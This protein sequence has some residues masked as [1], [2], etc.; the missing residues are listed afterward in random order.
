MRSSWFIV[1]LILTC[2]LPSYPFGGSRGVC[3]PKGIH[4]HRTFVLKYYAQAA[5]QIRITTLLPE[6]CLEK[7]RDVAAVNPF[8][9][10]SVIEVTSSRCPAN[11]K[12]EP[13]YRG[14]GVTSA[15]ADKKTCAIPFHLTSCLVTDILYFI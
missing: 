10:K 11:Y 3:V 12:K 7:K 2:C 1:F 6:H 4:T 13:A 15:E 9:A 8:A 5:D 14:Y